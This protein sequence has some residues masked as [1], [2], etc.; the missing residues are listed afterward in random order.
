MEKKFG[1][2]EIIMS[3]KEVFTAITS[4][5]FL[6]LLLYNISGLKSEKC[7][8]NGMTICVTGANRGIGFELARQAAQFDRAKVILTARDSIKGQSAV[9]GIRSSIENKDGVDLDLLFHPLDMSVSENIDNFCQWV[10]SEV[11]Q[12]D[13]LINNA[14]VCLEGNS[15]Q[16]LHQSLATNFFGPMQLAKSLAERRPKHN[17]MSQAQSCSLTVIN[18]SSGEGELCYLSSEAQRVIKDASSLAELQSRVRQIRNSHDGSRE[19]AFG[20][21]PTYS[22]S[23]AALNAAT[24]LLGACTSQPQWENLTKIIAVCPGDVDTDMSTAG[25][26]LITPEEAAKDILWAA[27]QGDFELNGKFCRNREI[28]PF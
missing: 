5:I 9:Q 2:F 6:F 1:L 14:G 19:L 16:V 21:T 26:V 3:H 11:G 22:L 25:A 10:L 7:P 24:R 13:L 28:I 4:S 15:Q 12:V 27:F 18:V 20:P 17:A 23:K 8:G